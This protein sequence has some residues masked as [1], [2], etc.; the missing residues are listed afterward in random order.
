MSSKHPNNGPSFSKAPPKKPRAAN[1]APSPDRQTAELEDQKRVAARSRKFSQLIRTD[2]GA[3]LDM[4][5]LG[6][7]D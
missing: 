6:K 3:A 2:P 7:K 5:G 4:L 1:G